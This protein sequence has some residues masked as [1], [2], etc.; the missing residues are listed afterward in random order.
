MKKHIFAF[1]FLFVAMLSIQA[2]SPEKAARLVLERTAGKKIASQVK[3]S[4]KPDKSPTPRFSCRVQ[5]N[6]LVVTGNTTVAMV[7]G[8]Y[9][10]LKSTNQGMITWAGKR[11][12]GKLKLE[13]EY[14]ADVTSPYRLHYYMNVVTAGYTTAYWD[15]KRWE[16]ELDWMALHGMDMPLINGAFEAIMYRVFQQTG[17]KKEAIDHFFTGPAYYP[18]NRMGNIVGWNGNPP[19][20]WYQQQ[21]ELTHRIL[22]RARQLG[23]APVIQAF[24]GFVPKEISEVYPEVKTHEL[25]W[26]GFDKPYHAHLLYPDSPLFQELGNRFVK[27]WEREF[28]K[29]D[30]YLADSF[31]EMDLPKTGGEE[32]LLKKL[33]LYGKAAYESIHKANPSAVWVMQGWT[34][35]YMRMADGSLLWTK[36]RLG[37]LMQDVP[38]D[39]LMILDLA[40]DYNLDF[41]KIDPSWKMYDGF[42]GKMWVYSFIP[43]M[44]GKTPWNGKLSTYASASVD[45][46]K[47]LQKGNLAGYGFAPEGIENNEIIY[48]LLSDMGWRDEAVNLDQWI[49][50][51]CIQRYGAYPDEM[52]S[53]YSCFLKSCYGT[54][55]DHPRFGWQLNASGKSNGTVN[56]SSAFSEGVRKFLSC[57]KQLRNSTLYQSDAIELTAQLVGLRADSLI[58][59]AISDEKNISYQDLDKAYQLL[60]KLDTLL[61]SHPLHRLDY[62]LSAAANKGKSAAEKNYYMADA[63]RLITTWGGTVNDYSARVWSG[64]ISTYY[65]E[66]MKAYYGAG[67]DRQKRAEAIKAWEE[68]WLKIPYAP[69]KAYQD[70]LAEMKH[71]LD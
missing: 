21:M 8:V 65:V 7:H 27:E 38:N 23:M 37:A 43:N 14:K 18:W 33:S 1:L 67:N 19:A 39:K 57:S 26:G 11:L 28:G 3:L 53:A 49:R 5:G 29:C 6:R 71:L 50:N 58:H 25:S 60:N 52:K 15:W 54:F 2:Q 41:W 20:D 59:Q 10:Y 63:K 22:N 36:K 69:G 16:Q 13:P 61:L 35:P 31:N 4:Y 56:D 44:G 30:Y 32:E 42:L 24:A 47:Y 48:E 51:Y 9:H 34:F 68:S 55:T 70:P 40:N 12:P 46:L 17:V 45:A 66:R 62:W 64:L